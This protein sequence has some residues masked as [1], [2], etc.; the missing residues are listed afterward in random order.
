MKPITMVAGT[1]LALSWEYQYSMAV[2]QKV[3]AEGKK[4]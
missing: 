1:T 2:A 4:K 3:L